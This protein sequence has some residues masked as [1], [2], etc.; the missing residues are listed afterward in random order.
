MLS[1]TN[2]LIHTAH[3]H[4]QIH[5]FACIHTQIHAFSLTHS[6]KYIHTTS[7]TSTFFLTY[8]HRYHQLTLINTFIHTF[9]CTPYTHSHKHCHTFL[10]ILLHMFIQHHIKTHSLFLSVSVFHTLRVEDIRV[11]WPSPCAVVFWCGESGN[12]SMER[13]WHLCQKKERRNLYCLYIF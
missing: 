9:S 6:S 2:T 1:H 5:H 4:F 11:K 7:N 10:H 12:L 3:K 8:T 13:M